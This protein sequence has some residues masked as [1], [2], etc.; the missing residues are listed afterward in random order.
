MAD[1]IAKH[2]PGTNDISDQFSPAHIRKALDDYKQLRGTGG[3]YTFGELTAKYY[4]L[5]STQH[6]HWKSDVTK[7]PKD[8]QDE[9]KRHVVYALTQLDAQGN[10]APVPLS[11]KW[12]RS[13]PKS[14]AC[15]Y[16]AG[17]PAS[18][19][20]VIT[21][22]PMPLASPFADRRDKY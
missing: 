9:I 20:I 13:G 11:F 3:D 10:E 19:A 2:Y 6:A 7:Y 1:D 5:T 14:I 15:T 12:V 4:N 17:P 8:V 22:Y 16:D 18:Y 21:G